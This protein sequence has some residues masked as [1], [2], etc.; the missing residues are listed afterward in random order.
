MAPLVVFYFH[1]TLQ[2]EGTHP[3]KILVLFDSKPLTAG[4]GFD[5]ES[6]TVFFFPPRRR[7]A[8]APVASGNQKVMKR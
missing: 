8:I 1:L 7:K 3:P 5:Q 4:N 2:V 6:G